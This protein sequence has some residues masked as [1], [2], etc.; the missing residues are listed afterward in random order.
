MKIINGQNHL[1]LWIWIVN[2]PHTTSAWSVT[3]IN[4]LGPS[5]AVVHFKIACTRASRSRELI[6]KVG[7]YVNE[8]LLLEQKQC[9]KLKYYWMILCCTELS[10]FH[11]VGCQFSFFVDYE[12]F[13]ENKCVHHRYRNRIILET[14]KPGCKVRHTCFSYWLQF[15]LKKIGD[16]LKPPRPLTSL[17]VL[18][19]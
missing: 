13:Q 3:Q 5:F 16:P 9:S 2:V 6:W 18:W 7:R 19:N 15:R 14:S 8:I 1:T 17:A 11:L 4:I 10:K 12:N